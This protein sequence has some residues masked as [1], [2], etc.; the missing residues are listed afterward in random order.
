MVLSAEVGFAAGEWV[1]A[2]RGVAAVDS[3]VLPVR[4]GFHGDVSASRQWRI[5]T[6][7]LVL[8]LPSTV[9]PGDGGFA[10]AGLAAHCAMAVAIGNVAQLL[11]ED[12]ALCAERGLQPRRCARNG[13]C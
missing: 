5:A 11:A 3:G 7:D 2:E 13:W 4:E 10:L 1:A 8:P 12:H 6:A 9:D